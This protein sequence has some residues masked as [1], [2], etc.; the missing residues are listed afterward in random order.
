[1]ARLCLNC[2]LAVSTNAESTAAFTARGCNG[3]PLSRREGERKGGER[4]EEG[5]K[6]RC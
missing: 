4:E 3:A 2:P 5:V 1:M 6:E